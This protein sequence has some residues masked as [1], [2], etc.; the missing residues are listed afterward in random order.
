MV[1]VLRAV[2]A[3]VERVAHEGVHLRVQEVVV[4]V[5]QE[6]VHQRARRA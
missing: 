6:Q 5:P 3:I 2:D 4:R 1:R